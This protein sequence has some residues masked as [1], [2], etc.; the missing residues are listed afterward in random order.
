MVHRLTAYSTELKELK[1]LRIKPLRAQWS[2]VNVRDADAFE[3]FEQ[4]EKDARAVDTDL[5]KKE[6][7]AEPA[8]DT[9][10]AQ[11]KKGEFVVAD[12]Y[13][14]DIRENFYEMSGYG[15]DVEKWKAEL[16]AKKVSEGGLIK[17][18]DPD[19][20]LYV[21]NGQYYPLKKDPPTIAHENPTVAGHWNTGS[22]ADTPGRF[23]THAKRLAFFR[24]GDDFKKKLF[25]Q[26]NSVN[27]KAGSGKKD[28]TFLKQVSSAFKGRG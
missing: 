5:N 10:Y 9:V 28:G 16:L 21:E 4:I 1:D 19:M 11:I 15:T 27:S 13:A 8:Y 24:G 25:I 17:D 12:P 14:G 23:S 2:K 22:G 7:P 20:Y 3:R 6:L 18:D 26:P